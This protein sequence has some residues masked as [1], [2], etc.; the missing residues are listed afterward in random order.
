MFLLN[1]VLHGHTR[2]GACLVHGPGGAGVPASQL[3]DGREEA[4]TQS[5]HGYEEFPGEGQRGRAPLHPGARV[6]LLTDVSGKGGHLEYG[7][8]DE[9]L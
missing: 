4:M 5:A 6:L 8:G 9:G 3:P 2:K 1:D 7:D